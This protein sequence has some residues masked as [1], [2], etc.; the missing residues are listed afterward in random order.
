M[1]NNKANKDFFSGKNREVIPNIAFRGMTAVMN[2]IDLFLNYSE[3]N[4]KALDLKQGQ[5]VIDYGCGPARYIKDASSIVG[6]TGEVIAIDIH[7]LA[8]K[9]V[10]KK[11]KKHN[12]TNVKT[13]LAT[14]YTTGIPD[15]TADVIYALDMFHMIENPKH[16]LSELARL[17]KTEGRVIIEDGHQER[18]ETIK[19]IKDSEVLNIVCETKTFVECKR[20]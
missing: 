10:D 17:V 13:V 8:I 1:K 16:L 4:I 9:K 11:I 19:K 20:D 12:L 18:A 7:P 3:R 14:G 6:K 2:M 5:T 15:R